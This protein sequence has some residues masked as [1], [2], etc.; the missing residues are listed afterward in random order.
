MEFVEN[1]SIDIRDVKD[2]SSLLE[3][4]HDHL[5][6]NL[7]IDSFEDIESYLYEF[8]ADDL[9]LTFRDRLSQHLLGRN[10]RIRYHI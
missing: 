8:T 2:I 5:N 7:V 10:G 6:W 3:Y 9:R 1:N 4:F